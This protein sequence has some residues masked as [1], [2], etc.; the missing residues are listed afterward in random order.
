M[1]DTKLIEWLAENVMGWR[2][3]EHIND[4][5]GKRYLLYDTS[6]TKIL[7]EK[8]QPTQNIQ[9]AWMLVEKMHESGWG[10]EIASLALPEDEWGVY[11]NRDTPLPYSEAYAKDENITCAITLAVAKAAGYEVEDED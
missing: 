10:F 6:E 7:R 4:A 3:F 9:D 11:L 2:P 5:T 8:F 1:T